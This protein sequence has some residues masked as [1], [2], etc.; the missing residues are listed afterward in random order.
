MKSVRVVLLPSLLT[1]LDLNER[2]VVVFDVLRA[3]TTMAAALS[4]GAAA[5]RVF[6]SIDA[7]RSAHAAFDGTPKL[8]AGEVHTL[9]P[10]GFDVGNSPG[11][12]TFD[13]CGGRT[14]FMSTTNG[15][16]ALVAAKSAAALYTGALVSAAAV[17]RIVS[18]QPLNVT[19]LC[20]G[21]DGQPAFDDLV[22][23]G[24]VMS[25]L[26]DAEL[27]NDS[28]LMAQSAW[29][30]AKDDLAGAFAKGASGHHLIRANL[31][32]DFEFAAGLNRVPVVGRVKEIDGVL[33][34]TRQPA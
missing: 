31:A 28:A 20:S 12:F 13:R 24:A 23:C 4:S 18:S 10:E 33:T 27:A 3:T 14:I 7:A 34:V 19:L 2:A 5:I 22:G 29:N 8:L 1:P 17:A 11:D 30:A 16:K 25:F 15:T 9:P 32:T 21:T 6:G 26:E